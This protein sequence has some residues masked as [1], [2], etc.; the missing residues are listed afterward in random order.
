MHSSQHKQFINPHH[1][2]LF[3]TLDGASHNRLKVPKHRVVNI[4]SLIK[5]GVVLV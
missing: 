1:S 4:T 2:Y 3:P 5:E